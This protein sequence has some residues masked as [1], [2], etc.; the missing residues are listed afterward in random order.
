MSE[1]LQRLGTGASP[2]IEA[3]RVQWQAE[4]LEAHGAHVAQV[5]LTER[6]GALG[7]PIGTAFLVGPDLVLTNYHV[8]ERA[9]L[10]EGV[11][12]RFGYSSR[13]DGLRNEGVSVAP[14]S[15]RCIVDQSP[16]APS[17]ANL[18]SAEPTPDQLD[19]MLV[20]LAV[21]IGEIEGR[22]WIRLTDQAE[23]F[24]NQREL[25]I[26]QHPRGKPLSIA[27]GQPHEDGLASDALRWA[28]RVDTE[29][30]S[31]GSPVFEASSR[32]LIALHHYGAETYNRG[33]PVWRIG[34]R[35][36]VQQ[37][38]AVVRPPPAED[39]AGTENV[40]SPPGKVRGS[41][42]RLAAV[43]ISLAIAAAAIIV[44]PMVIEGP[45]DTSPPSPRAN[46]PQA[47][48]PEND[49]WRKRVDA[50]AD[51]GALGDLCEE[52]FRA[53]QYPAAILACEKAQTVETSRIWSSKL[54]FLAAAYLHLDRSDDFVT[55][56]DLLLRRVR[57]TGPIF[58]VNA[59][60][61][62]R[63]NAKVAGETFTTQ[64]HQATWASL[65]SQLIRTT[66]RPHRPDEWKAVLNEFKDDELAL[67]Y[68][69]KDAFDRKEYSWTTELL[70]AA[71]RV[72]RSGVWTRAYPYLIA[73]Q[74]ILNEKQKAEE[75]GSELVRRLEAPTGYI[76]HIKLEMPKRLEE[77]GPWV[78]AK[79]AEWWKKL[80]DD[81]RKAVS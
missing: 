72:E 74:L 59:H 38:L 50:R 4:L 53:G 43:V 8:L 71:R 10:P 47:S 52:A 18:G 11:R 40:V 34:C 60:W 76:K 44:G 25:A 51:E 70:E 81:A 63:G 77:V 22:G 21:S 66:A 79:Y 69:G 80:I 16:Y 37:A 39:G 1:G 6:S 5:V 55:A 41:T 58:F 12:F 24:T 29:P 13:A 31:S 78:P 26:L 56:K 75:Y 64:E 19:F 17:E 23:T 62:V 67:A 3:Y 68:I 15:D 27:I 14:A 35:P 45:G 7:D 28:Y 54:P 36:A 73:A 42:G 20:R 49:P 46:R 57:Q 61:I 32:R 33:V 48:L 2:P 9:T 30:G 65:S